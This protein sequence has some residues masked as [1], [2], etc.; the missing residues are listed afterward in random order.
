MLSCLHIGQQQRWKIAKITEM[1]EV[2]EKKISSLFAGNGRQG[3]IEKHRSQSTT[4]KLKTTKKKKIITYLSW[5]MRAR[6]LS[7]TLSLCHTLRHIKCAYFI[8]SFVKYF[9]LA[10]TWQVLN[11]MQFWDQYNYVFL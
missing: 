4:T 1:T 8:H 3:W 2:T 10:N 11:N 6:F 9:G 7:L 5:S